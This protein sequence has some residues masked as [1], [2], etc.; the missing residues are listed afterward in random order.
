MVEKYMKKSVEGWKKSLPPDIFH[1]LWEN[2]TEPPFTGKYVDEERNGVYRCAGCDNL[3]FDSNDKF[4]SGSGWPSFT[5]PI[6]SDAVTKK[7]DLSL[8]M[9]RIEVRCSS[10]GGHLG[11]VFNDGPKPEGTRYCINSKALTF[12]KS[13]EKEEK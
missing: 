10:C 6:H 8:G 7:I 2:G 9:K 3:L 5:K 4:H 1:I 12:E 13:D 11:H